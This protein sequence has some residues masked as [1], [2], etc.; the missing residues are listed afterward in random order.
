MKPI[1]RSSMFGFHR[2]DVSSFIAKQSKQY[3]KR[4]NE[5]LEEEKRLESE[6]CAEKSAREAEEALLKSLRSEK[7]EKD[8]KTK[9]VLEI[10]E[11]LNAEKA[12]LLSGAERCVDQFDQMKQG[13]E[14]LNQKLSEALSFRDKAK[15][16]DQLA[17]VLSG[18]LSGE[19]REAQEDHSAE[20]QME[21]MKEIALSSD[22]AFEQKEAVLRIAL[23]LDQLSECFEESVR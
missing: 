16:F 18:I 9:A 6:L 23:L 5:L 21:K 20:E 3:E 19:V 10:L 15:K 14:V 2:E 7:E 1:F 13:M 11:K 22:S 8:S 17:N 12:A 4:I